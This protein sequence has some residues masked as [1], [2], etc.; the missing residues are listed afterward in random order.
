MRYT[1][2][3]VCLVWRADLPRYISLVE[4]VSCVE[5]LASGEV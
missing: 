2:K 5:V 1:R 3:T 4:N